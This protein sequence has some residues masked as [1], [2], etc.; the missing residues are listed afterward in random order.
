MY[1]KEGGIVIRTI[2]LVGRDFY[3]CMVLEEIFKSWYPDTFCMCALEID[4][5]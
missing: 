1:A 3:T 5:W 4:D 2:L